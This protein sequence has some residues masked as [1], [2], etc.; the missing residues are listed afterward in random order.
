MWWDS[1]APDGAAPAFYTAN[2]STD[3]IGVMTLN[4]D[5]ATSLA[6]GAYGY[7]HVHKAGTA[8]AAYRDALVFSGALQVEDIQ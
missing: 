7:L 8:S 5:A 1:T 4:I 3:E 6:V 2:G